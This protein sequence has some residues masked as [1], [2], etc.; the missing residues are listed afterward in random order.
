M[1]KMNLLPFALEHLAFPGLWTDH[2]NQQEETAHGQGQAGW[3]VP[4]KV[5][6]GGE[7][8]WGLGGGGTLSRTAW[9]LLW[10]EPTLAVKLLHPEKGSVIESSTAPFTYR[11]IQEGCLEEASTEY[12]S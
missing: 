2:L 1:R 10:K 12:N 3:R 9:P 7:C 6:S 8:R 5:Y 11:G 4:G